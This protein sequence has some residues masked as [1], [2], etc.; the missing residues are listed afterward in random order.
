MKKLFLPATLALAPTVLALS[1]AAASAA[2]IGFEVRLG[3]RNTDAPNVRITNLSD[4]AHLTGISVHIGDTRYNFDAMYRFRLPTGVDFTRVQGD[5]RRRGRGRENV[6]AATF[7][8]FAPTDRVRFRLELDRDG[9]GN[10]DEDYRMILFNSRTAP[11]AQ[12]TATFSNNQTLDLT[13]PDAPERRSYRY[14]NTAAASQ[15]LPPVP[16]PAGFPLMA[17]GIAG[18]GL[19]GMR[20][21][22]S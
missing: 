3:G 15:P 17:L 6:V 22:S 9:Q 20:R 14:S 11:N 2:T 4:T 1:G 5:A 7:T 19:V 8:N 18:L 21:K 12:F 16:L 10:T 13:L